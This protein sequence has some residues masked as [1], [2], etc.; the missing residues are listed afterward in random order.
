M[1]NLSAFIDCSRGAVYT[2]AALK[3]YIDALSQMGYNSLQLY[4]EDTLTVEGEAYFGYLR[5]AYSIDEIKRL[6]SYARSR[7]MELIPAVQ[8]LAHLKGITRWE[9]YA[10]ITDT[11]NIL[12]MGDERTYAL[13]DNIFAVC[14]EAYSSNRINIGMDEA[15]LVGRGK[16]ADIHGNKDRMIAM[17]DHIK[18]VCEI[19]DKYGFKP[20]MWSDMFFRLGEVDYYS[21]KPRAFSKEIADLVPKNLDLIYWEYFTNNYNRYF[22]TLKAHK[23]LKNNI[24][25]AGGTWCWGG[26]TPHNKFSIVNNCVALKACADNGIEE[27]IITGWKDDG[28]ESS[29]FS[30]LPALMFAVENY[31]G[32]FDEKV[33]KIK[34]EKLFGID[35]DGFMSLDKPDLLDDEYTNSNP[36]KYMLFSDPFLGW[37]DGTVDE[38]KSVMF[39][40]AKAEID[41]YIRNKSYGY[42]F[43][44]SSALCDVMSIKYAL[45]V[46]TRKAYKS[47]DKKAIERLISHYDELYKRV[48]KLYERFKAQWDKECKQNG[49]EHHDARYG[50]LLMRIKHCREILSE[51]ASG[52]KASIPALEEEI[53]PPN[54]GDSRVG[55]AIQFNNYAMTA[56]IKYSED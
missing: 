25:F 15:Y 30:T 31:Y 7:G 23:S 55:E 40:K 53:L 4:T 33:I 56:L 32:N 16:Y 29:L 36:T 6:D 14:R 47:G 41:K 49:F 24:L 3:K 5:G 48:Q 34:F 8:T 52:K 18:R 28:A 21:D 35:C 26:I 37:L 39:E 43:E 27:V 44:T 13:I 54:K 10:G 50:A 17:L 22:T 12:L 20:M 9:Q 46:R 2:E 45:G 1:K 11:G 51:Y 42:I 19:A 38:N